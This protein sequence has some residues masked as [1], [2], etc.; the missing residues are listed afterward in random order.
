[1]IRNPAEFER[2][3]PAGYDGLFCWD[4]LKGAFGPKIEPMDFDGV[5]ERRGHFLVFETKRDSVE[6]SLGSEITFAA[7]LKSPRWTVIL[8]EKHPDDIQGWTV[9]TR[10]GQQHYRGDSRALYEWCAQWFR[11]VS[12]DRAAG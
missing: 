12:A 8:C 4:F 1:M 7:L 6:M 5:V 10:A 11:S 2:A 9:W 3:K